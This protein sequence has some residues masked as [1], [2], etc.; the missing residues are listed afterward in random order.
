MLRKQLPIKRKLM[1]KLQN[2]LKNKQKMQK[3]QA[4]AAKA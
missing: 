4:E 3:K 1:Q 2:L